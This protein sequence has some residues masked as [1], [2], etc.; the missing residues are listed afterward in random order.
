MRHRTHLPSISAGY[1]SRNISAAGQM[2]EKFHGPTS[3]IL[4]AIRVLRYVLHDILLHYINIVI[5]YV[6]YV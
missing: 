5:Y 3:G 1:P 6:Y 2:D 4:I